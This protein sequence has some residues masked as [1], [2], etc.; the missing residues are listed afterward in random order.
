[1]APAGLGGV[2]QRR[3]F[4]A[5]IFIQTDLFQTDARDLSNCFIRSTV[6]ELPNATIL[7]IFLS[8]FGRRLK[9]FQ[10]AHS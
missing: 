9:T 1:M 7:T 4:L 10:L 8:K 3:S 2:Y 5:N 6:R